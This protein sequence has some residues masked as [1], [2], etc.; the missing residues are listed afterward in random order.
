MLKADIADDSCKLLSTRPVSMKTK[1]ISEALAMSLLSAREFQHD[2]CLQLLQAVKWPHAGDVRPASS[3]EGMGRLELGTY[4]K[5]NRMGMTQQTLKHPCRTR[6]LNAY[7]RRH[8]LKGTC[9]RL[10]LRNWSGPLSRDV[11]AN[12]KDLCWHITLGNFQGALWIETTTTAPSSETARRGDAGGKEYVGYLHYS[13]NHLISFD[14]RCLY[15][16][17]PFTGERYSLTTFQDRLAGLLPE[18]GRRRLKDLGF[19]VSS[20]R[21]SFEA[22]STLLTGTEDNFGEMVETWWVNAP[23]FEAHVPRGQRADERQL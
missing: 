7:L 15:M 2:C 16:S 22:T 1:S 8:D 20:K 4:D 14:S 23:V 9:S 12:K 19:D 18:S 13:K 11:R 21:V 10:L 17:E 3:G 5:S 6:N